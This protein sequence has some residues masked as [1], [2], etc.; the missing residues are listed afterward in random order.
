MAG[1]AIGSWYWGKRS[2]I[3]KNP[4]RT[5]GFLE[6]A[7]A[8]YCFLYEPIFSLLDSIFSGF[9][10]GAALSS[11]SLTVF[12]A[13][14]IVACLAI[15]PPTIL[16]GGTLPILVR[17]FS[18]K[19]GEVGKN[20]SILYFLNSLGA[21]VG[22]ILA[23]FYFL[24][25][26]GLRGSTFTGAFMD[27]IVGGFAI[28]FSGKIQLDESKETVSTEV[29]TSP[30]DNYQYKVVLLIAG[31][32]G[33][34]AMGYEVIWLR[35][36]IPI[37]SSSTYSFTIILASFITGITIGSFL[38]YKY[39]HK[40]KRP[41]LFLGI[42]QLL[43]IAGIQFS[44][45]FYER[46]PY[47]IW[48]AVGDPDIAH[49]S[50]SYY[51][52]IQSF[53]VF[54]ILLI[55]TVFMGMSLPIATKL[56]VKNVSETGKTVGKVFAIN[57]IGTVLGSLAVGLILI[58]LTGITG[59]LVILIFLNLLLFLLVIRHKSTSTVK[60][61]MI[62]GAILVVSS[63][64]F[65]N[66]LSN[67]S[68][69]YSIMLSEAPRKINRL[70]PP[71]SF[72]EFLLKSKK[73]E[74]IDYYKEGPNGTFVVA[75]NKGETY[76]FTNGK[77][78]ANSS[79]DLRTQISLGLTPV[80]LHNS[81]D[82]VFVIG[83][84]AGTTIG[85]VMSHPRVK[86]G[87]VAEISKE[88]L[89]ASSYFKSINED[90]LSRKNLKVIADDGVSALRL[91]PHKYDV[92]ISQPS[93][94]WSAGV[95]NLFTTDFFK[96]CKEKL[97]PGGFVAQW[98]N[99]YEMDDK[100]LSLIL[101]TVLSE[102]KEVDLWHIGE[103]DIL[104]I[105]SNEP[106]NT[107]I[108]SIRE[109]YN[110][111]ADKLQKINIHSFSAFLSQQFLTDE[112]ALKNYAS[113]GPL[114][115]ENLP[116]LEHWAPK[117]YYYNSRPESFYPL[118]ERKD[119]VKNDHLLI[120]KYLKEE[121]PSGQDIMQAALFQSS[122]G[123][124]ELALY[125]ADL[126]PQVYLIWAEKARQVG[127]MDK[128]AEYESLAKL[129]VVKNDPNKS[130]LEKKATE[131]ADKGNYV[132]AMQYIDKAINEQ[133]ESASLHYQKGTFLLSQNKLDDAVSEFKEAIKLKEDFIDAYVNLAI[134]YG[135]K[136][137][138]NDVISLLD[139]A[140]NYSTKNA[141]VYFNRGYAKA[142]LNNMQ[143]AIID[144]TKA[145]ELEPNYAQAYIVRGR[146]Y[147]ALGDKQCCIDFHTAK[148]KGSKEADQWINQFC[149]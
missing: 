41:F 74:K 72:N 88:V 46:L 38:V 79:G 92:I 62:T 53:Y 107:N 26:F 113:E 128:V 58:P 6:I 30:L 48:N 47:M 24:E 10:S 121:N 103:S 37:L 117:A 60:L 32:S 86:Y 28:W 61:K 7:I 106:I 57:T 25:T 85:H 3:L 80:I 44:M 2:D 71:R 4:L 36:L 78:D 31:I 34:C 23:G 99:L 54:L 81:P 29:K 39:I 43:I 112:S 66:T 33:F 11:D 139:K 124:K 133:P 138:Y 8:V 104:L 116:L 40:I 5:F 119:I 144:L 82:S 126:N 68:W 27:L 108:N 96:S 130:E 18:K 45:P 141:K 94:P 76:L 17:H 132:Q 35:L 50:Y 56:A 75:E 22:T 9:V 83:F 20:V 140:E 77:G 16:M 149:K 145:I 109:H 135:Q 123:S 91:S 102:F 129:A 137:K 51:I 1:L 105:C 143:G 49:S 147:L 69:V 64:I 122:G 70:K 89:E 97:R 98:F 131:L 120:A 93:N 115:T 134:V 101:R 67:N 87:E 73:H 63:F 21:V 118:D 15:L 13:R 136:Q 111:S 142:L 100:S 55:P 146:A 19:I 114:N 95:G 12:I 14:L 42:C 52:F 90:P 110:L 84:G 125:L 59:S 65:F 148:T 127:D